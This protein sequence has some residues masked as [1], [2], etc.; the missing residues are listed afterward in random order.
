MTQPSRTTHQGRRSLQDRMRQR[1]RMIQQGRT[2]P[3]DQSIQQVRMIQEGRMAQQSTMRRAW[4]KAED[5]K[6]P[7]LVLNQKADPEN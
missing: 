6:F 3:L 1:D 4:K 5:L 7:P 2:H